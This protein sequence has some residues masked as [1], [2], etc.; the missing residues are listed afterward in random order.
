MSDKKIFLT[1]KWENLLLA[2]Y[3]V[4]PE[5]LQPYLPEGFQPDTI[6]G[7]AFISL[8]AFDFADTKV[9]GI[10][11]P[12]NVNFPEINLRF[13]V[14]YKEQRGVVFIREFVPNY[15]TVLGAN[16]FFNENYRKINM[17]NEIAFDEKILLSHTIEVDSKEYSIK[18]QAENKSFMPPENSAEHFFKEHEWGFGTT[19]S[20]ETLV[21]RVEHPIW[22]IYPVTDFKTNFD[23]GEVYGNH[24]KSIDSQKP[25][26]VTL[27]KG[28]AIKVYE[29]QQLNTL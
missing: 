20:G 10:H 12:F 28:S 18:V 14:K 15:L 17:K 19:R 8:V 3:R 16:I 26:N 5:A 1:A 13:Y 24:W 21:Y 6:G 7:A 2:S 27:A 11:V 23:F 22:E 4:E 25:Y 29:A 9:K